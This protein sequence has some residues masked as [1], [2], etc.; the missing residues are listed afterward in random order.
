MR[1]ES[2]PSTRETTLS[3]LLKEGESCASN[4]AQVLG[5]SVQAMRRHLRSLEEDGLVQATSRNKGP[6]RPSNVWELTKKGQNRFNEG[7]ENF[8]LDLLGSIETTLSEEA[9]TT[10]L[11]EQAADKASFYRT[12]IGPGSIQERTQRLVELRH[13][14]GHLAECQPALDNDACFINEYHCS[15][16]KIAEKYPI[17]CEQELKM[18]RNTFPDCEVNRVDWRLECGHCCG[19][20]IKPLN[21]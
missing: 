1:S 8:A 6:G 7:S 13:R 19:F 14:E 16:G 3:L 5:I 10:L 17:V 12:Q 21:S 9:M 11:S 20:L 18:I 2:Q 4:L 15:I